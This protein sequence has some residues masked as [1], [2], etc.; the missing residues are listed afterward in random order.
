[1]VEFY[2]TGKFLSLVHQTN[3]IYDIQ[4]C[5]TIEV[6]ESFTPLVP[7]KFFKRQPH[8]MVKHTQTIPRQQ[9]RNCLRVFDHFVGSALKGL[10]TTSSILV[11]AGIYSFI[12]ISKVQLR[13][14]C[15]TFKISL[16]SLL[17]PHIITLTGNSFS[18]INNNW[19]REESIF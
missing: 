6:R 2:T 13:G 12:L 17:K 10:N 4:M 7:W 3:F 8:K 15:S 1:M 9:L 5:V 19:E 18:V 11:D 16:R 14:L